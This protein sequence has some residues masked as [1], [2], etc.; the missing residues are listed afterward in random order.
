M[1]KIALWIPDSGFWMVCLSLPKSP[2]ESLDSGFWILDS[3][4]SQPVCAEEE[5]GFWILDSGLPP[6][7]WLELDSGFWIPG[8]ERCSRTW[9]FWKVPAIE[10]LLKGVLWILD[11]G[12]WTLGCSR[13]GNRTPLEFRIP[14]SGFES[15][16][17]SWAA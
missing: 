3:L 5:P 11:S 12:F 9:R 2:S 10:S 16:A 4:F 8:F 17:R 6:C 14:D 1:K 15:R 7:S 13:S